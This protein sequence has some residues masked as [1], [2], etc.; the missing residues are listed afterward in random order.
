MDDRHRAQAVSRT[1]VTGGTRKD[2]FG[3]RLSLRKQNRP[4]SNHMKPSL[5]IQ[6]IPRLQRWP[7]RI[8]CAC[9]KCCI[10]YCGLAKHSGRDSPACIAGIAGRTPQLLLMIFALG[11]AALCP[12]RK[13]SG[14][15][16]RLTGAIPISRQQKAVTLLVFLRLALEIQ[17]SV[18]VRSF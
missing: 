7:A 15:F 14:L 12:P 5:K 11:F 2:E 1:P 10:Y 16:R 18:G 4:R 13:L 9:Q 3:N 17:G 6:T 8:T